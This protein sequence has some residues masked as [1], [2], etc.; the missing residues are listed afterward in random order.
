MLVLETGMQS[1]NEM[2]F[3]L[4]KR[5]IFSETG[6]YLKDHKRSMVSNRLRKRLETCG[7]DTYKKYYDFL[8]KNPDGKQEL[9]EFVNCLTTN[10][11]FFFRHS[12]QIEYLTEIILPQMMEKQKRIRIWSAACSSGE[13]PYSIAM[14]IR[15]KMGCNALKS[16]EIIASDI[17]RNMILKA[18][19]GL[20]K[21]YAV[22]RMP[23]DYKKKYFTDV[24]DLFMLSDT[25]QNQ[26]QFYQSNLLEPFR[27]GQFDVIFCRNVMIYFNQDSKSRALTNLYGGL[28]TQGYLIT[29][30]AESL[31]NNQNLFQFIQPAIYQKADQ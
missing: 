26:V 25:I 22:Q 1:I 3:K 11:T 18:K 29:G 8:T 20:Y 5:L 19:A 4:I 31:L 17:N 15:E 14:Q 24:E 6:V 2:E 12:E 16:I 7:M 21:P 9:T 23:I 27:H 28:R 30:Y 10:E 13:E